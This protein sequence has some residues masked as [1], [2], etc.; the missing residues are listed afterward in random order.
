MQKSLPFPHPVLVHQGNQDRQANPLKQVEISKHGKVK[1][2][3]KIMS[4]TELMRTL[5]QTVH[6]WNR[7]HSPYNYSYLI[8]YK[9]AKKN[10][11]E[12]GKYRQ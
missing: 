5:T 11:L 8:F 10:T 2:C 3:Q 1:R 6:Q 9:D 4:S 7:R 12:K